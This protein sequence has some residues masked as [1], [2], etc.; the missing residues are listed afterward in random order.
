MCKVA[1]YF[2]DI[3]LLTTI[4]KNTTIGGV[5]VMSTLSVHR[6]H[7]W[8]SL[9]HYCIKYSRSSGIWRKI[10]RKYQI[11]LFNTIFHLL[12]PTK[13]NYFRCKTFI[14]CKG[15]M[16]SR[17]AR[18]LKWKESQ[19]KKSINSKKKQTPENLSPVQSDSYVL[20]VALDKV[21]TLHYRC[22]GSSIKA[23]IILICARQ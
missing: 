12:N 21:I 2:S 9:C 13:W 5:D 20:L 16:H 3:G 6:Q 10:D 1:P 19:K 11:S 14:W 22:H 4:E 7:G 18:G 23:P 15:P 17:W 8:P